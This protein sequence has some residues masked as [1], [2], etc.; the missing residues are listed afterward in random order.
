[1]LKSHKVGYEL[2]LKQLIVRFVGVSNTL[3]TTVILITNE[4]FNVMGHFYINDINILKE[5][6]FQEDKAHH[7]LS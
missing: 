2:S 3:P 4:F 5:T 1:M 7:F 6:C